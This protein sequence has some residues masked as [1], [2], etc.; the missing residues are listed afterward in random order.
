MCIHAAFGGLVP[1][2][3]S[4]RTSSAAPSATLPPPPP[5]S[6]GASASL[7][8]NPEE[9]DLGNDEDEEAE[10][11]KQTDGTEATAGAPAAATA[12]A[13]AATA[14]VVEQAAEIG[15]GESSV[16]AAEDEMFLE[17]ECGPV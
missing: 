16:Y 13:A 1:S 15:P 11:V 5:R 4:Q 8:D 6:A 12:A 9:I 2:S 17:P 10:E 14:A 7:A 3:V